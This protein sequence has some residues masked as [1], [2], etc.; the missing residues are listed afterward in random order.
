MELFS[1]IYLFVFLLQRVLSKYVEYAMTYI[2]GSIYSQVGIGTPPLAITSR[3]C[4]LSNYSHFASNAYHYKSSKTAEVFDE[5]EIMVE[6]ALIKANQ[7]SDI[8]KIYG[9]PYGEFRYS[10]FLFQSQFSNKADCLA[11][12]YTKEN[13]DFSLVHQLKK[14]ELINELSFTLF[15]MTKIIYG[16]LPIEIKRNLSLVS[17]C[18]MNQNIPFWNCKLNAILIEN[19]KIEIDDFIFFQST[20]RTIFVPKYF[21][22]LLKQKIF[23]KYIKKGICSEIEIYNSISSF[24]I[25]CNCSAIE[26]FPSL[27]FLVG[28]YKFVLNKEKLFEYSINDNCFFNL[29]ESTY[30]DKKWIVG[31]SFYS[32]YTTTFNYEKDSISFFVQ[33]QIHN[34]E[35]DNI[36]K[37]YTITIILLS[38]NIYF[39]CYI[40]K[41]KVKG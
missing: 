2:G 4:L 38:I 33:S 35:K 23:N 41:Y 25:R 6:E 3:I 11:L 36:Q 19:K 26:N 39:L 30:S 37:I 12:G 17:Q 20:H 8:I 15:N 13:E 5:K 10:F 21:I 14:K 7:M 22:E 31:T 9:H 32:Q 34:S 28:N 24:M 16:E 29:R 18:E 1:F 27:S 40:K